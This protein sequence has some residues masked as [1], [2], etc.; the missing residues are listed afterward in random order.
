MLAY[1]LIPFKTSM[2]SNIYTEEKSENL[3]IIVGKLEIKQKQF[4]SFFP[5]KTIPRDFTPQT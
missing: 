1:K 3:G 4:F 2:Q 5:C